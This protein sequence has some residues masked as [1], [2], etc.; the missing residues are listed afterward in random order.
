MPDEVAVKV[1]TVGVFRNK[2][3]VWIQKLDQARGPRRERTPMDSIPDWDFFAGVVSN[4]FGYVTIE[5]PHRRSDSSKKRTELL[6]AS[7]DMQFI[8][9]G[10]FAKLVLKDS[11]KTDQ[12][13]VHQLIS[14]VCFR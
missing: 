1:M 14:G 6:C 2:I 9:V 7:Y 13:L 10:R 3:P 5:T 8:I 12:S 4:A 11:T